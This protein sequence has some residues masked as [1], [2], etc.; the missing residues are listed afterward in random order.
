MARDYYSQLAGPKLKEVIER[1]SKDTVDEQMS[2]AAEVDAQRLLSLEAFKLWDAAINSDV[3]EEL[4]Q[5][6]AIN[7]RAMLNAVADTVQTASR[8]YATCEASMSTQ[9]VNYVVEQV[10]AII[11]RTIR[12]DNNALADAVLKKLGDVRMPQADA[13]P[14]DERFL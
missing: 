11:E 5:A 12:P 2:L 8:V 4:K 1:L 6:A 10:K 7:L 14:P 3:D 9:A 13:L